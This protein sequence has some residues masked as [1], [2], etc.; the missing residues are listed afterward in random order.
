MPHHDN[1]YDGQH[2]KIIDLETFIAVQ[3]IKG[4]NRAGRLSPSKSVK[5]LSLERHA[6]LRMLWNGNG[7][8]QSRQQDRFFM[9]IYTSSTAVKEGYAKCQLGNLPAGELDEFVLHKVQELLQQPS[10]IQ[11]VANYTKKENMPIAEAEVFQS[12]QNMDKV[13]N[14]L[15]SIEKRAILEQLIHKIIVSST[16]H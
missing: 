6:N 14:L 10:L 13:F 5:K 4:L 1:V 11:D 8:H 12:F 15:V 3:A 2:E 9:S 7:F 16:C